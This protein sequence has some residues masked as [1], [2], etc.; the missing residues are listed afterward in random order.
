MFEGCAVLGMEKF[1]PVLPSVSPTQIWD[2]FVE[3][4]IFSTCYFVLV[5]SYFIFLASPPV[6][7]CRGFLC[8][9]PGMKSLPSR[10]VLMLFVYAGRAVFG[11]MV[12]WGHWV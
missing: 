12:F 4:G 1:A 7:R 8:Q 5:L 10:S 6:D 9:R 3:R 2:S 11:G